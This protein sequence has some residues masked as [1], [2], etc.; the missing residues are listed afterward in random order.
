MV[1]VGYAK[2]MIR[3]TLIE[4][5]VVIAIIG[6]LAAMMMPSLQKAISSARGVGCINNQKQIASCIFS[7]N[8]DYAGAFPPQKRG[9]EAMWSNA[10]EPQYQVAVYGE[11]KNPRSSILYCP[12]DDREF[13]ARATL[14]ASSHSGYVSV[15][16][17]DYV[18]SSYVSSVVSNDISGLFR[19]PTGSIITFNS[20]RKA[21][22]NLMFTE[23]DGSWYINRWDQWFYVA[24][25]SSSNL[26]YADGHA[27][28]VDMG[29][30]EF[31]VMDKNGLP[32][33]YNYM[34]DLWMR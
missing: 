34:D 7:Y 14:A 22:K 28:A 10:N 16:G 31:S 26:L 23:G 20:L 11:I 32:A 15:D 3:F 19:W 6:I 29:Y 2:K 13:G 17:D 25:N 9:N 30:E 27:A 24:H 5:L 4:M 21:S 33:P 18:P 12:A 1:C 8:N